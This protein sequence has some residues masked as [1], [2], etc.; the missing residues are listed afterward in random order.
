M[1]SSAVA[2]IDRSNIVVEARNTACTLNGKI[3]S[4][5][6]AGLAKNENGVWFRL[7]S[8]L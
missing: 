1:A 7:Y 5:S 2:L 6:Y 3:V 8:E 4:I